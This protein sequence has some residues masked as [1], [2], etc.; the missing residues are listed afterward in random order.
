MS[1]RK[2][3][4]KRAVHIAIPIVTVVIIGVVLVAL[5]LNR[6][7]TTASVKEIELEERI[8]KVSSLNLTTDTYDLKVSEEAQI[9]VS[10][11]PSDATDSSLTYVSDNGDVASVDE[12]GKIT[13]IGAG[14]CIIK[15]VANSDENIVSEIKVNVE[16]EVVEEVSQPEASNDDVSSGSST[17]TNATSP[18]YIGGVLIANKSYPLPSTY[19]PGGLTGDTVNAFNTMKAAAANEGINL[20]IVS[21]F[22]SYATQASLYSN[23]VAG[24]G[25][26]AADTFSARPGHSEHQSGLA[27]D[28][29]SADSSFA[30]TKEAIWVANNSYKYGFIVRYPQG[31]EHITGYMYEPWHLRYVGVNLATE[32]YNSGLT[33]EEYLGIDSVYK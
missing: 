11:E 1:R 19:N 32:L 15:V 17:S 7:D 22:R 2:R 14:S 23:Y 30:G 10:V 28:V 24:Y 5:L 21:G 20:F 29:N 31:K 16:E 27:L 26:V 8:T 12:S 25:Q 13:A 6:N 18:T 33:L 4:N 3:N 9:E